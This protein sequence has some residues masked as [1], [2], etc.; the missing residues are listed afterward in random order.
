MKSILYK[1][2]RYWNRLAYSV[3]RLGQ[4]MIWDYSKKN[5]DILDNSSVASTYSRDIMC[6]SYM[7]PLYSNMW[8]YIAFILALAMW[9]VMEIFIKGRAT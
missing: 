1:L 6:D 7:K 5:S 4:W 9:L 8:L 3:L 2:S